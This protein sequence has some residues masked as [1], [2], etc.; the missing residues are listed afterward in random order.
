MQNFATKKTNKVLLDS[1]TKYDF[2]ANYLLSKMTFTINKA[3]IQE[4]L[5][6]TKLF[7][8]DLSNLNKTFDENVLTITKTHKISLRQFIV[9]MCS[10]IHINLLSIP[11]EIKQ[12]KKAKNQTDKNKPQYMK[13]GANYTYFIYSRIF[14][15]STQVK[16][17]LDIFVVLNSIFTRL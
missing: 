15:H 3:A 9:D 16:D 17:L 2:D 4:L 7:N 13:E 12:Q 8:L 6:L 11:I 14:G 10:H 5:S 1:H